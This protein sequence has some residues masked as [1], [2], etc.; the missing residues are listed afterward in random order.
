M[1]KVSI[2]LVGLIVLLLSIFWIPWAAGQLSTLN[3]EYAYL[4]YP[5]QIGIYLTTI[6]FFF[7]LY[8]ANKLLVYI[9]KKNAF[10][11]LSAESLRT[12]KHCAIVIV[13]LYV[14][15]IALLI[16]QNAL[17]PSLGLIGLSVAFA[18]LVIAFFAALLQELLN[19]ALEIKSENELTV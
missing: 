14:I 5:V 9:E 2:Y 18:S 17:H 15:G 4:R 13:G 7:A 8:Q 6:P 16:S 1:L 11:D 12:I 10:S 19:S 3:P